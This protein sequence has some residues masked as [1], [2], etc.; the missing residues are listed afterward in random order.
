MARNNTDDM[1][2]KPYPG[3]TDRYQPSRNA[4]QGDF[5]LK[6]PLHRAI[7]IA[8]LTAIIVVAI[9]SLFAH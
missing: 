5:I 7:F 2:S 3:I 9:L 6:T 8:G 4:R 1:S